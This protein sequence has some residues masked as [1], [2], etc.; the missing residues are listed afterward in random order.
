MLMVFYFKGV[1]R[2]GDENPAY[3]HN[4]D[5]NRNGLHEN[6]LRKHC[7]TSGHKKANKTREAYPETGVLKSEIAKIPTKVAPVPYITS[8]IKFKKKSHAIK[9]K[10]L[11]N[12]LQR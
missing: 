10:L 12:W 8:E 3:C 9:M 6:G 4:P 7:P 2:R 11:T 5:H 1:E